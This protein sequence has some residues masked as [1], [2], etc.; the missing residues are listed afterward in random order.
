[1][2]VNEKTDLVL[3]QPNLLRVMLQIHQW[4][5]GQQGELKTLS[6]RDLYLRL[7]AG[8]LEDDCKPQSLKFLQGQMTERA[9]RQRI[10]EFQAHGLIEVEASQPDQRTKRAVP[11]EKFVSRLNQHL[12]FLMHLCEQEFLMIHKN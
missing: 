11:T 7:A 6:G 2:D 5:V 10:R 8:L 1:M 9:T 3:H 4:E 12:D